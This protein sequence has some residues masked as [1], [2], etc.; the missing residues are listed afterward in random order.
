MLPCSG[1][2]GPELG[3]DTAAFSV[4]S[5]SSCTSTVPW[6]LVSPSLL[7][8][9]VFLCTLSQRLYWH[10]W[11]KFCWRTFALVWEVCY[12]PGELFHSSE[13]KLTFLLNVASSHSE[14]W[15]HVEVRLQALLCPYLDFDRSP[16]WIC[17]QNLLPRPENS[18]SESYSQ[19]KVILSKCGEKL[20]RF[21]CF[22]FK[23][24]TVCQNHE[25]HT[26]LPCL[27]SFA[28]KLQIVWLW[29]SLTNRNK[30]QL[31]WH[32]VQEGC[33]SV[34]GGYILYRRISLHILRFFYSILHI[35]TH[36]HFEAISY[37]H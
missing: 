19:E 29:I 12:L 36:H 4:W 11:A 21:E 23:V 17:K 26:H 27:Y 18:Y 20:A 31:S 24:A 13:R 37:H 5:S 6:I 34:Y 2:C 30:A 32:I 35:R 8:T 1:I 10:L 25:E 7:V 15:F 14:V 33:C 9:N 22:E 16:F 28:H 3:S